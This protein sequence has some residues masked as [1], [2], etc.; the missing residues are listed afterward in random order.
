MKSI[1][2][3][4]SKYYS[5]FIIVS[6]VV[7]LLFPLSLRAQFEGVYSWA[8]GMGSLWQDAARATTT[9]ND[10]NV[11]ITGTFK[12][13][14]DFDPGIGVA[15][16]VTIINPNA[17]SIFLA[18]YDADGNYIYAISIGHEVAVDTTQ[19]SSTAIAVDDNG[20]TYI[21][22]NF[23]GT[24]DFDPGPGT[25]FLTNNHFYSLFIAKYDSNGN[26]VYAKKIGGYVTSWGI[27]VDQ[28]ENVYI[29]GFFYSTVD[30][31]PG[32]GT[33]GFTASGDNDIFFAKY[34][35]FGNYVFVKRMGSSGNDSAWDLA[36]DNFDNIYIT[37]T[38]QGSVNFNP[39]TGG[40]VAVLTSATEWSSFFAKYDSNGNYI[41]AKNLSH[42]G[43][44]VV[45]ASAITVDANSNLY[46]T[47]LLRGTA[48]F[49]PSSNTVNL[50]SVAGSDDV[51][52][53]KYDANGNYLF[54]KSMGSPQ[55]DIAHGI[56][57]DNDGNAHIT[58]ICSNAA[59]FDPGPGIALINTAAYSC[60]L[61][62]YDPNGNYLY[63]MAMDGLQNPYNFRSIIAIDHSGNIFMGGSFE[64]SIDFDP[65]PENAILTSAGDSDIYIAKYNKA[66]IWYL[67]EDN[68]GWYIETRA[69]TTSPGEGWTTEPPTGGSGDCDDN[70]ASVHQSFSFY[71]DADGDGHG[72]N[73]L[74]DVCAVS[75]T[76]PPLGYSVTTGDCDDNDASVYQTFTF[77]PD[78]DGDGHGAYTGVE[79]CAESANTP[80]DGYLTTND[81][82]DDTDY[83]IWLAKPAEIVF[84]LDSIQACHNAIP[85]AIGVDPEGGTWSGTGISNGTFSPAQ[86]GIGTHTL[87]Y[88]VEGDGMCILPANDNMIVTVAICNS[89]SENEAETIMVYPTQTSGTINIQAQNLNTAMLMDMNGRLINTL[90]IQGSNAVLN[91]ETYAS[92]F[93]LLNISTYTTTR[94]FKVVK[95]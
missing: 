3:Y 82:C 79:I 40:G 8:H 51:F 30:F 84:T 95:E 60:Y 48:D 85:F 61:A 72:A 64:N 26:Y 31:D 76:T 20:N 29:A 74:V 36:L 66:T 46:L 42:N 38:Y 12:D 50:S 73:S 2:R 54:A 19:L 17:K 28:L 77:Y 11:Y 16:L 32:P 23:N 52:L 88:S 59:D 27:K 43:D 55:L 13:T 5:S 81:D 33:A 15:D 91:L 25:A 87:N 41:Y 14:V 18:K 7:V 35:E 37:G 75:A 58:G 67:D 80:P 63:V 44:N 21:M 1:N 93:Y 78:A 49:D 57:L 56:A 68:D 39:N 6:I 47:G 10:G 89:V 22:G 86:A 62:K 34:D 53:A 65:S 83:L 4:F 94:V 92:G 69:S 9:D 45:Q 24:I 71:P 90:H 70:D